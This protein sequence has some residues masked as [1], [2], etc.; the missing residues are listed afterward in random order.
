MRK[1]LGQVLIPINCEPVDLDGDADLDIVAGSMGERRVLWFENLGGLEFR[2]HP[3]VLDHGPDSLAVFGFNMDYADL[4]G[5]C[6]RDIVSVAWPG[7]IVLL[8][9][10]EHSDDLW[11]WSLLGSARP[12][13]PVS[14]RLGDK[15]SRRYRC[16]FCQT[17][18]VQGWGLQIWMHPVDCCSSC[19]SAERIGTGA[20][21]FW[22]RLL[23][24][25]WLTSGF[26]FHTE[27]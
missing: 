24:A 22:G 12:D 15:R 25:A 18:R 11:G 27:K 21:K 1:L 2:E 14:V 8:H 13:Q 3:I 19:I 10:P 6:R 9:R 16:R 20:N 5:D 26:C 23:E 4:D 7:A 17:D